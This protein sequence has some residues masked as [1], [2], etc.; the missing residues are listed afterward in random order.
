MRTETKY[1]KLVGRIGN[2]Y[3]F[4]D[5]I[6]KYN[7]NFQGATATVLEPVSREEYDERTSEDGL[8]DYLGECWKDA[9]ANDSTTMGEAEWCQ[10]AYDVD[11]DEILFDFSGSNL[12]NQLRDLGMSE[13][14]YPV[15]ACTGGGRSFSHDQEFDEVYDADLLAKIKA[16]ETREPATV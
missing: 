3:Y 7:D 9:V 8:I 6:F 10:Y 15:F 12:W 4:C 1:N 2:S 13:E 16:V 14:D 5:D 11:G